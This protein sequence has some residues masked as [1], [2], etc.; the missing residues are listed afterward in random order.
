MP[1]SGVLASCQRPG[2]VYPEVCPTA[3]YDRVTQS[4]QWLDHPE[5]SIQWPRQLH[6]RCWLAGTDYSLRWPK[7]ARGAGKNHPLEVAPNEPDGAG[8]PLR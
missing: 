1:S 8:T 6:K 7:R 2:R 4:A 3:Q 5:E